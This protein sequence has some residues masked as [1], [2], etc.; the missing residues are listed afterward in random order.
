MI[1]IVIQFRYEVGP[2]YATETLFYGTPFL[3]LVPEEELSLGELLLLRLSTK[4]GL[5][6]V[7][8]VARV[9]GFGGVGHRRGG[10]VLHLFQVEVEALGD[11]GQLGH[12]LLA[13]AGVGGDE[14]G[15]DLLVKVLLAVDAV[16][17]ALEVVELLEGRLAHEVEHTV[18]GVLRCHLQS[19]A[20]MTGDKLPCVFLG[21]TVGLLVL[22]AV[23]KQVIA[24]TA[25]Y[26]AALDAR[27]G[28]YGVVDVEQSTVIGVEVRTDLRMDTTGTTAFLTSIEVA[29]VH[30]IH[31]GRGSAE[32]G[33]V[34]LEVG[35]RDHLTNLFH[36]T[37]F[38]SAGDKLALM[39]RDG[40]EGA[41]A[42]ASA[43][44]VHRV[45][46]HVVGR[47][48]LTLV[49]RVRLT[50]IRQVEG[51]VELLGGHRRIWRIHDHITVAN[52]L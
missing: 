34:A 43:M 41:T 17:L 33:E 32:V 11:D 18:A 47:N 39:G 4:Y 28:V 2:S 25:A 16:E 19:S 6:R 20:Y 37:L 42:E 8:V 31:I 1:F 45:L 35:H 27:H 5:Q 26:E 50:S 52:G 24:H 9:P 14:V 7:G 12:V 30:T 49:L 23:E 51:S 29:A 3:G 21:R 22:A 46:N 40:A 10:E 13:A 38:R 44:D 48:A 36:N 15:D